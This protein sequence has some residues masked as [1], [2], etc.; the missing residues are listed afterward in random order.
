MC[1]RC[2]GIVRGASPVCSFVFLRSMCLIRCKRQYAVVEFSSKGLLSIDFLCVPIGPCT[3]RASIA[4]SRK[5]KRSGIV[6]HF[7]TVV[8]FTIY[9]FPHNGQANNAEFVRIHPGFV[10]P[11]DVPEPPA[12]SK[13]VSNDMSSPE[14]SVTGLARPVRKPE[15]TQTKSCGFFV[16]FQKIACV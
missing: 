13:D 4:C 2:A 11:D 16:F 15:S 5:S 7:G 8:C 10:V 14:S 9:A 1:L 12:P 3:G 6:L